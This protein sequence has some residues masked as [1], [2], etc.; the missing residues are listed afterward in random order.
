MAERGA[1]EFFRSFCFGLVSVSTLNRGVH[2][3]YKY[4]YKSS[5][6]VGGAGSWGGGLLGK[7]Y[8]FL[9]VL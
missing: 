6:G 8:G 7:A 3:R 1:L 2:V 9:L 4:I 5:E